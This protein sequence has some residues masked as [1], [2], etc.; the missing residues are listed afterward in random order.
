MADGVEV[1]IT[2]L[3]AF[4]VRLKELSADMQRKVIR[5]GSMAAA[6][7][8]RKAAVANAPSLKKPDTRKKNPRVPGTLKKAIFAGRSKKRSTPGK[9]MIVVGVRS[10]GKAAKTNRDAFYWRFVEDGHLVRHSGQ[11]IKGGKKR[12]GLERT[13][14]KA[15]NATFVPAVKFMARAFKDNQDAAI[16]AFNKRL[17]ARI[18]KAQRDLN[19][20]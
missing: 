11:K 12:A 4:S 9:E 16:A 6:N 15:A 5:A 20:R 18:Q 14:L 10:G 13:R 3:P 8:F 7:I 1:K 2:G 17:E 19:V